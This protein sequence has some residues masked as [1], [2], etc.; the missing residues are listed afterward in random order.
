MTKD[1]KIIH[2]RTNH[3]EICDT[4][5]FMDICRSEQLQAKFTDLFD[6]EHRYKLC[7]VV[8]PLNLS[9]RTYTQTLVQILESIPANYTYSIIVN[10]CPLEFFSPSDRA[11]KIRTDYVSETKQI[12][13]HYCSPNQYRA[14]E[15]FIF[16]P[17]SQNLSYCSPSI[18]RCIREMKSNQFDLMVPMKIYTQSLQIF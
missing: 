10:N 16:L 1:F 14:P 15:S 12:L 5:C 11:E 13:S 8:Q 9:P 7:L 17:S 18:C 3:W 4:P 2:S 6:T